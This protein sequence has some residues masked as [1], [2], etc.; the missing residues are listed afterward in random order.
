MATAA[1]GI[2]HGNDGTK[3]DGSGGGVDFVEEEEEEKR[4]ERARAREREEAWKRLL[5]ARR[6]FPMHHGRV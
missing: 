5:E 4:V 1:A 3:T 2:I 6:Q